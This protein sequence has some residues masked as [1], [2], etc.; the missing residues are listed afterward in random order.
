V[1]YVQRA[2]AWTPAKALA[3]RQGAAAADDD[4]RIKLVL[5]MLRRSPQAQICAE[6]R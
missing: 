2:S 1:K 3:R 6:P 5:M 4:A